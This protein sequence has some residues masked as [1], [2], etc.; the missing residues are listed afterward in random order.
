M[1]FLTLQNTFV[2]SFVSHWL[3]HEEEEA[4]GARGAR[5]MVFVRAN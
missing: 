1:S 5:E 3:Y 2:L 4:A